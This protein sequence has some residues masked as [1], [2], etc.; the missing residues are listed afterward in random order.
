[1]DEA[2]QWYGEGLA[3]AEGERCPVEAGRCL[4]GLAAVAVR[5]DDTSDALELLDRAAA[6]FRTHGAKLDLDQ[7]IVKK[8][9]LQAITADDMHASIVAV[10]N[11]VQ[12]EHPTCSG[13]PRRT[14]PSRSSS[15]TSKTPHL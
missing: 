14:A 3:W 9:A 6:Y 8:V 12:S 4:Q 13:R 10:H 15:P 1:V 7:I 11:F 5:R 2:N